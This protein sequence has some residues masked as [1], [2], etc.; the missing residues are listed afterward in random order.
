MPVN[1]KHSI[2]IIGFAANEAAMLEIF[3]NGN[4]AKGF[5]L[6]PAD[7]AE[8]L[9]IG[10]S[11]A[12]SRQ[13]V[14]GW[15]RQN[16]SR[17]FI[18]V[19]DPGAA[20]KVNG[21]SIRLTRPLSMGALQQALSD[22]QLQLG[23]APVSSASQM[24]SP[25]Q[26]LQGQQDQRTA[27]FAEWQARKERSSQALNAWKGGNSQR[28]SEALRSRFSLERNELNSLIL[29]AQN[30]LRQQHSEV[31]PSR[32][33]AR[34][35][36]A[37]AQETE[38]LLSDELRAPRISA[39]MIQQ[40]CG[41]LPDVNLDSA[42]ERRR[43]YFNLDGLLLPWIKRCIK[44]G[45]ASGKPQQVVGVPGALFY[46]PEDKE[47][48][49][50]LDSDL[51]LQLTRTRFGFEEISLL[52]REPD[53]ELPKG[54]RVAADELL[55]QLALFT[56]RGRLP[57]TLSAEEPRLLNSIP[58]FERLLETPHA[59]SIAEL[60]QSQRLSAQNIASMLGVPQ[61]FVF[62]FLVAADAI[63]LYCP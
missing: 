30:Q 11:D 8:S 47:F 7:R 41:N 40:C 10:I 28:Q 56:A 23:S 24:M 43:V 13:Q 62:S 15:V 44:A 31:S 14:E 38:S 52:E 48:L 32:P 39:E 42:S 4:K 49:V 6:V 18:A 25:E 35:T 54:R 17:P 19:V 59:R 33:S 9:L 63:G 27:A 51:L 45:N 2:G 50:T 3:F 12:S 34:A 20:E 37:E 36:E 5:K 21:K 29:D 1:G 53:A 46:L 22:L 26:P 16:G 60:W 57:D 61:R 55:W 58:D